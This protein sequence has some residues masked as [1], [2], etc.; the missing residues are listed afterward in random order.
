MIFNSSRYAK[1]DDY[2]YRLIEAGNVV[3][4]IEITVDEINSVDVA[5]IAGDINR[6]EGNIYVDGRYL[7]FV[8]MRTRQDPDGQAYVDINVKET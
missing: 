5:D 3:V 7:E 2:D 1:L 8:S 6:N 4:A